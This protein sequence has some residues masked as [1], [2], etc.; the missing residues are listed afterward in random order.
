MSKLKKATQ[1][2]LRVISHARPTKTHQLLA[3]VA[4]VGALLLTSATY[5]VSYQNGPGYVCGKQTLQAG[6]ALK[7][8]KYQ[9]QRGYPIHFYTEQVPKGCNSFIPDGLVAGATNKTAA[10]DVNAAQ[11]NPAGALIDYVAW[12][13]VTTTL[14]IGGALLWANRKATP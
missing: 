8:A 3:G 12:L 2:K 9:T 13:S 7:T 11:K 1:H 14:T 4:L 6:E 5:A 10:P